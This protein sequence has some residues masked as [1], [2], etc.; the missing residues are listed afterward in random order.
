MDCI[1][2]VWKPA[3][4]TSFDVIRKIK[5]NLQK[6]IKI[7]HA[8]TLDP[9]AEGI[10]ILCTGKKTKSVESMMD[11][12]KVYEAEIQLGIETDTMDPEGE[13]VKKSKVNHYSKNSIKLILE[14]FTG[15]TNQI[16]PMFSAL[17]YKG[18]RLYNLARK[19]VK[20]ELQ[21]RQVFIK[22]V[23]FISLENNVLKISVECG[24]G[25]YIRALARD[26]A[27]ELKT[28]GYLISLKRTKVGEYSE[29]NALS[30]EEFAKCIFS[31]H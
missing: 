22:N 16:P 2:P 3:G 12:L 23:N 9:F 24:R 1:A 31:K 28:V 20:I 19:G 29:E 7:G 26:I 18:Q 17:K 4:I 10:L 27:L 8:G 25:V 15:T 13:I 5:T 11:K 21:P 6:K 14:K 30:I